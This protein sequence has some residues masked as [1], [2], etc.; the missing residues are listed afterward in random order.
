M[1]YAL[2]HALDEWA[3]GKKRSRWDYSTDDHT[4]QEIIDTGPKYFARCFHLLRVGDLVHIVT[5]DH[6]RAT[7]IVDYIDERSHDVA[8]SVEREHD[9]QP[10]LAKA[11]QLAYRWR[12]PRGGG[13]SIVDAA[14]AL[15]QSGYATKDDALRALANMMDKAA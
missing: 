1:I 9:D 6:R 4:L 10:V 14:G 3:P 11:E 15:V 8:F 2:A 13:H 12:G 5:A 7:L